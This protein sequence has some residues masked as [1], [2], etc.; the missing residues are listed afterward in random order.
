MV[1]EF[2]IPI[3]KKAVRH[4]FEVGYKVY[5][6]KLSFGEKFV[7]GGVS[8]LKA[9]LDGFIAETVVC[10]FFKHEFPSLSPGKNDAFDLIIKNFKV[11][12][13]K[14]G[15]CKQSGRPKMTIDK[16]QLSRKVN[17]IDAFLFTAFKGQF[18]QKFCGAKK[19]LV[20][21]PVPGACKLWLVGWISSKEVA[22]KGRTYVW[23]NPDGTPRNESWQVFE[24]DLNKIEELIE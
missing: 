17:L 19:L 6:D 14:V 18:E 9:D 8:E 5:Q 21:I 13:K 10:E 12:V 24:K 16:K 23:T 22:N 7:V 15:F 4:G 1:N 11:D 3:T 2:M 20:W